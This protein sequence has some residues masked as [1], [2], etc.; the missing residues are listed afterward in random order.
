MLVAKEEGEALLKAE[1]AQLTE[2][3]AELQGLVGVAERLEES[4]S[5]RLVCLTAFHP[6]L[7]QRMLHQLQGNAEGWRVPS[8]R[9]GRPRRKG[10]ATLNPTGPDTGL[11]RAVGNLASSRR[12]GQEDSWMCA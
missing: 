12:V 8:R 10:C 7:S 4:E 6:A 5:H 11:G 3:V 1:V 2:R 9:L